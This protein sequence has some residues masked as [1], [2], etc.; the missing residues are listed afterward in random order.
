MGKFPGESAEKA[1]EKAR[2]A[3]KKI[4]KNLNLKYT[5]LITFGTG[6]K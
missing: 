1:A 4:L 6:W 5:I 3:V 2:S